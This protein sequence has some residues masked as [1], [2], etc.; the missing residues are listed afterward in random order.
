MGG[1]GVPELLIILVILVILFGLG[2]LPKAAGQLGAGLRSFK[3]GL[4]GE[5][6]EIEIG[7]DKAE[8]ARIEDKQANQTVNEASA[9]RQKDAESSTNG[10][11]AAW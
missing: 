3:S 1:F 2:K 7:D 8:P 10:G 9:P 6:D 4:S 11:E 5:D